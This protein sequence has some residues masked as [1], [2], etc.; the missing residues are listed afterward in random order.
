MRWPD[1]DTEAT[2]QALAAAGWVAYD[3]THRSLRPAS[4][5]PDPRGA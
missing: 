3:T 1:I 2:V 4:M 5:R